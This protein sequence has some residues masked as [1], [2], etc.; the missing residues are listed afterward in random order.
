MLNMPLLK[1][2]PETLEQSDHITHFLQLR[3]SRELFILA[4]YWT[5]FIVRTLKTLKIGC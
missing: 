2:R 3:P 4:L 5:F 1:R